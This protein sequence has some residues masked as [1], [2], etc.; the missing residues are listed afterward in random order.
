MLVGAVLFLCVAM[1]FN[2]IVVRVEVVGSGAYLKNEVLALLKDY[3]IGNFSV[4]KGFDQPSLTARILSLPDVTFCSFQKQGSVFYVSVETENDQNARAVYRSLV[5]DCE[6]EVQ[7][8]VAICGTAEVTAGESVQKG[9]ALIG[10]YELDESGVRRD[11]LAVGYCK[12]L[13][14]GE[15][16]Y[17]AEAEGEQQLKMAQAAL[18]LYAEDITSCNVEI[19]KGET[20]VIYQFQ[21]EY[22]RTLTINFD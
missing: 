18:N 14:R 21:Y 3:G 1:V 19:K 5:A 4:W 2:G 20:G 17:H 15:Y 6:G 10:A 12:V 13:C 16:S 9:Q 8:I 11:C 7:N 22:I